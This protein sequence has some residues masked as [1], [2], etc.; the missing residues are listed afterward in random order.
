[1][2]AVV[3]EFVAPERPQFGPGPERDPVAGARSHDRVVD[4]YRLGSLAVD[5]DVRPLL[6][7]RGQNS[8]AVLDDDVLEPVLLA[9]GVLEPD[10]GPVAGIRGPAGER[11]RT[12]GS[13][14]RG[15]RPRL[16]HPEALAAVER[17]GRSRLDGQVARDRRRLVDP[18]G[19]TQVAPG[20]RRLES[21]AL[22]DD[23]VVLVAGEFVAG[24]QVLDCPRHARDRRPGVARDPV[25]L[26]GADA[27]LAPDP[28]PGPG[29]LPDQAVG[30]RH[31]PALGG[32]ADLEGG[33]VPVPAGVL[34]DGVVQHE[35][36]D[37][38]VGSG[39]L[40]PAPASGTLGLA[41]E[42]DSSVAVLRRSQGPSGFDG[43]TGPRREREG[44]ARNESQRR[45]GGDPQVR[46]DLVGRTVERSIF[47]YLAGE[48]L[49][50]VPRRSAPAGRTI[51]DLT[52]RQAGDDSGGDRSE[53]VAS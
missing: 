37:P 50:A 23:G 53:Q 30:D 2:R 9:G 48:F 24:G 51:G 52:P 26:E 28:D 42:R 18:V 29:V 1:V 20:R 36:P 14:G 15:Q 47:G 22:D 45:S 31:R 8:T 41:G 35:V 11:D 13:A 19:Y 7:E 34:E 49:G 40:D 43:Q 12:V 27:R 33:T 46:R 10:P 4:R 21:R 38:A 39:V 17:H 6:G 32:P 44:H 3:D 5:D 25:A 16:D